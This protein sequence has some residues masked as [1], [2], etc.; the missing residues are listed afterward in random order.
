M[1]ISAIVAVSDNGVIGKDNNLPW[2]LPADLQYFRRITTGHHIVLGRKNYQSIGRPLPDRVNIVLSRDTHFEA[3][4]CVCVSGLQEAFSL[5]NSAGESE[6]FVIGGAEVY[7]QALS[8]CS[9]LYLT[10]VH[11]V[12]SGDVFMPDMGEGWC[13]VS[14]TE[15]PMDAKNPYACSFL[16]LERS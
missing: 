16:V 1:I 2:R 7:R 5:A 15:H 3:P 6:C 8:F 10:Q 12:F 14:R 13:E 11:G 4:G 9:R